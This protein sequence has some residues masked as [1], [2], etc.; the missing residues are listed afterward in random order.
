[1][2]GW[3]LL[4]GE[5]SG[6]AYRSNLIT[7]LLA[8]FFLIGQAWAQHEQARMMSAGLPHQAFKDP[9]ND[10]Q[11]RPRLRRRAGE[12]APSSPA[13]S[14]GSSFLRDILLDSPV[15]SHESESSRPLGPSPESHAPA[16]SKPVA[17][18]DEEVSSRPSTSSQAPKRRRGP[19]FDA[20]E[21]RRRESESKQ[22]SR[23]RAAGIWIPPAPGYKTRITVDRNNGNQGDHHGSPNLARLSLD[24]KVE[25]PREAAK[26][27]KKLALQSAAA[28]LHAAGELPARGPTKPRGIPRAPIDAREFNRRRKESRR[29]TEIRIGGFH[30]PAVPGYE[31]RVKHR[32]NIEP[33][34]ARP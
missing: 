34:D 21:R 30:V 20:D 14:S 3:T 31:S 5:H 8:G 6:F 10:L 11:D 13:W 23:M 2:R 12:A 19:Q 33:G 9:R 32:P 28:Q 27:R 18:R 1:M 29:R 15:R 4:L 25:R 16:A 17:T 24:V 7:C 22:R 26:K